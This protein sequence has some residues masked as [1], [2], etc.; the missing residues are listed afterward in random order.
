MLRIPFLHGLYAVAISWRFG[1]F[2]LVVRKRKT[3]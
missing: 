1:F 3:S 2:C